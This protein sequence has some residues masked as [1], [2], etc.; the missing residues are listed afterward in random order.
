MNTFDASVILTICQYEKEKD[1]GGSGTNFIKVLQEVQY[2]PLNLIFGKA[3][4]CRV[5]SYRWKGN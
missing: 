5:A 4:W 2:S 3:S 1:A